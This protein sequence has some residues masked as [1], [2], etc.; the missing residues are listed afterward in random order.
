MTLDT[1]ASRIHAPRA[2]APTVWLLL[3]QRAGDNAQLLALAEGLGWRYE[4][5]R[6]AYHRLELTTNLLFDATLLGR[7]GSQSDAIGPPWPDLVISSGRRSEP[8]ARWIRQHADPPPKLVH[9]GRPWRDAKEFDLVIATPQYAIEP[10]PGVLHNLL[11]LH[12]VTRARLA[13]AVSRWRPKLARLPRP[14]V[15]VLVGGSSELFTLDARTA[16]R[17]GREAAA[18]VRA[19]GGSLLVTTSTRTPRGVAAAL[20]EAIDV[21]A[22]I[23]EWS[24]DTTE[25]PYWGYLALADSFVVTG[26][27][28]SMLTEACAT[29]KPVSIFDPARGPAG[30]LSDV[31][32]TIRR[33]IL[34]FGIPR[35]SR[36]IRRVHDELVELGHATFLGEPSGGTVRPPPDSIERT[37]ARVR[38]L[39]APDVQDAPVPAEPDSALPRVWAIPCD[40]AGDN[41]QILSLAEALGWPFEVKPVAYRRFGRLFDV[42]RGTTLLGIARGRSSSLQPPWPDLVI[43]ASMRNEPVCRWIRRQSGGKTKTV[44]I[45]KPWARLAT[46]DLVITVPEY[47]WL[48]QLPN[49][50]HNACSLHGVNP[51]KLDEQAR[52]WAPAVADLPRP[53]VAVLVGGYAGP[54]PFD[55]ENAERL[56]REASDMARSLGG[57]L[58]LTTSARTSPAAIDAL[59]AAIDVPYSLFRWKPHPDANPYL[60]FLALADSI[61]V[62]CDSTSMLA[63]ACATRKPVYMFDMAADRARDGARLAATPVAAQLSRWWRRCNTDRLKAFLYRHVLLRIAPSKIKRDIGRVH[64]TLLSS[65]RAVWLGEPFPKRTPPPFDEMPR[66]LERVQALVG[67]DAQGSF[68]SDVSRAS[69]A[70]HSDRAPLPRSDR[71]EGD[72]RTPTVPAR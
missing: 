25:N 46:F 57:S 45:G 42:W 39:F 1:G 12:G 8:I 31:R 3:G 72:R 29:G 20:R 23:F 17:L 40:R 59:V 71:R 16:T 6:L 70:A 15:A 11:P 67:R 62:T 63:E 5:K 64:E 4:A 51:A 14:R 2:A 26:D 35:L 50:L 36:D 65:R 66:S 32:A 7:I 21:P 37:V 33:R 68:R 55:R 24:A 44:H 10:Q 61:I 58:L 53:F 49:V 56:G 19:S 54:Y 22:E 34:N 30:P 43:S 18:M 47:R 60:G 52:T 28:V 41:S 9:V 48:P 38:A 69:A 27:S 13:T